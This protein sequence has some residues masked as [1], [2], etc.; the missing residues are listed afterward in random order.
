MPYQQLPSWSDMTECSI[1]PKCNSMRVTRYSPLKQIKYSYI[2]HNQILEHV[3]SAKYLGK[4][5]GVNMFQTY[6]LYNA[7]QTLDF[8]RRNLALAPRETKDMAYKTLVRPKL[9]C[10]S[11]VWNPYS[12]SHVNQL[13]KVQRTAQ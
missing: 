2:L 7:T 12:K 1:V 6:Q 8:L 13:E 4:T 5:I 3:T 9:E 11:P 10:A